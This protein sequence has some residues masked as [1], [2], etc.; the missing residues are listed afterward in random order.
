[1]STNGLSW[2]LFRSCLSCSLDIYSDL[3]TFVILNIKL[4]KLTVK[5]SKIS[6]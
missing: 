1:M 6:S 2:A 3:G 4:A 5:D